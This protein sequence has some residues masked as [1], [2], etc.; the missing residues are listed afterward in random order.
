MR[1]TE[2]AAEPLR[3]PCSLRD[4]LCNVRVIWERGEGTGNQPGPPASWSGPEV[5]REPAGNPGW[6]VKASCEA[7]RQE[8]SRVPGFVSGTQ[9]TG[10]LLP[11]LPL[12]CHSQGHPGRWWEL[13]CPPA[14]PLMGGGDIKPHLKFQV[15][16]S[17]QWGAQ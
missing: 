1:I 11:S 5:F 4:F 13:A 8:G 15:P 14:I 10:A 2:C 6:L 7:G 12:P 16:W 17:G 3:F 9:H